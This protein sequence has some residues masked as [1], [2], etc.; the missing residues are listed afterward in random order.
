MA[1]ANRVRLYFGSVGYFTT[2]A[3]AL[4]LH[5]FSSVAFVWKKKLIGWMTGQTRPVVRFGSFAPVRSEG[6]VIR[7]P[8]AYFWLQVSRRA[9]WSL[10]SARGCRRMGARRGTGQHRSCDHDRASTQPSTFF[11]RQ[12]ERRGWPGRSPAI[13][14]FSPYGLNTNPG[15]IATSAGIGGR[16]ANNSG[17][18]FMTFRMCF[19]SM[20]LLTSKVALMVPRRLKRSSALQSAR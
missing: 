20:C 8:P 15:P 3:A 1:N 7:S 10:P 5:A 12:A 18:S 14:K 4:D 17:L 16:S 19:G 2:M 6:A 9:S 11:F 13:P